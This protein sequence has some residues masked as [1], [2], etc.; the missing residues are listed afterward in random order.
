M[1]D[2]LQNILFKKP[3]QHPAGKRI[4]KRVQSTAHATGVLL[5]DFATIK[6]FIQNTPEIDEFLVICRS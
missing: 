3:F 4:I 2:S 6:V 5:N 1:E